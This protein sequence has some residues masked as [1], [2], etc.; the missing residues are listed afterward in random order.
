MQNNKVKDFYNKFARANLLLDFI[1][2][3]KR[4]D[5]IK[6]LCKNFVPPNAR[7]LEIGC[8][9]GI[10]TKYLIKLSDKIVSLD[11]SDKNIEI[12]K[13]YV[14]SEK[15]N[16]LILDLLNQE[17]NYFESIKFDVILIA[18]VLEHLPR[19]KHLSVFKLIES[20]LSENGRVIITYPSP[21]YQKFL[22][23]N[24][25]NSLQI[26]DE[27]IELQEILSETRLKPI[28]FNYKNIWN[29]NDY[30]H[31][32]LQKN[33]FLNN[34]KKKDIKNYLLYR[35]KKYAWRIRHFFFYQKIKKIIN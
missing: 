14:K 22:K 30:I 16:F 25:P 3:N 28:N 26:I 33:I 6:R 13:Q 17:K 11:I 12:A 7:I 9:T 8:G 29:N 21:E 31:L 24:A 27:E 20:Y 34:I 32:V 23:I 15:V 19:T 18:D 10:I 5:E 35:F 4:Q 1:Y 2:F